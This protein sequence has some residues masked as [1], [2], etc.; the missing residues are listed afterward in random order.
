[1]VSSIVPGANG[2]AAA[3]GVE[4]RLARGPNGAPQRDEAGSRTDSVELSSAALNAARE[5]VR[6]GIAQVQEALALGQE[7][8]A[9]LVKAQA[10]ARAGAQNDL[11]VALKGFAE[12]LEAALSR[13]AS[14]VAGGAIAIQAEPGGQP[15]TVEGVDLRLKPAPS[16]DDVIG[17]AAGARVDDPDLGALVQRS[18]E[19]LQEEMSR[20]LE[21]VRALEAH[22]GFLG[23]AESAAAVRG[24]LNADTARLLALQVRQGLQAAGAPSIANVEP[25]AVLS[26]FRA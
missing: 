11:D 24:D 26:L 20:L 17:V 9:M 22:Q 10:A 12:R 2:A 14:L 1:M 19:K 25:Q 5:S 16:A 8:Q 13:G 3:F 6:A 18:L 23:A 7:A 15:V 4:P 21:Q